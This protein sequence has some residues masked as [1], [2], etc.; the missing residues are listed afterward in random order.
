[1]RTMERGVRVLGQA[2][3][4]LCD[5]TLH[6]FSYWSNHRIIPTKSSDLM[7]KEESSF[8]PGF[9]HSTVSLRAGLGQGTKR[10]AKT[11]GRPR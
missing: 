9:G 3:S 11:D 5:F 6:P 10:N 8:S 1:M 2:T 4:D 7:Q